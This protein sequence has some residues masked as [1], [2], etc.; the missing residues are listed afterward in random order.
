MWLCFINF[1][2]TISVICSIHAVNVNQILE[3]FLTVAV[4]GAIMC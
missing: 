1:M 4:R 3:T 2:S